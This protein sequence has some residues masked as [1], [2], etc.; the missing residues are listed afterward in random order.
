MM[1]FPSTSFFGP[2][3]FCLQL[4]L[5]AETLDNSCSQ[6][7]GEIAFLSCSL[8]E[9][10]L[11]QP[12]GLQ[13]D[14]SSTEIQYSTVTVILAEKCALVADYTCGKDVSK[15]AQ[16][17]SS[18]RDFNWRIPRPWPKPLTT[19]PPR[20]SHYDEHFSCTK[21]TLVKHAFQWWWLFLR[22]PFSDLQY[23]VCN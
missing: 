21:S 18:Y 16:N 20:S 4:D 12:L 19:T 8:D 6:Y 13:D 1:A 7:N 22:P 5:T 10:S 17:N 3:M 11:L 2:A 14:S 23:S 9:I 15:Q